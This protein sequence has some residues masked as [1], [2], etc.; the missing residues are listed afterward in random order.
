MLI[1]DVLIRF[2]I[3]AQQANQDIVA[4]HIAILYDIYLPG[5]GSQA[6]GGWHTIIYILK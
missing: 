2:H 4:F 1:A 5:G 3:V 6:T